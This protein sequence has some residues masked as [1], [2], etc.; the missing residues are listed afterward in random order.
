MEGKE[1]NDLVED[2]FKSSTVRW[3]KEQTEYLEKITRAQSNCLH[4][5]EYRSGRITG[6]KIY[7]V[8]HT[9]R[10]QPSASL[11]KSICNPLATSN[12]HSQSLKWGGSHE[13]IAIKS[14][15]EY[16]EQRHQN[17]QFQSIGFKIN[18]EI[19][20]Y[21]G[22]SPDG[23]VSCDC[24]GTGLVEVKCSYKYRDIMPTDVKSDPQYCLEIKENDVRIKDTHRYAEKVQFNMYVC[25]EN[26]CDF[27]VWTLKG[28]VVCRILRKQNYFENKV[29]LIE[30]F[31]K[32]H[33]VP[34]LLTRR[35]ELTE[36]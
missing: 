10:N 21:L 7:D 5:F 32:R 28:M 12:L 36:E 1:L 34:E 26:Y 31:Y 14:Y 4:W 18:P 3:N 17:L 15:I 9:N 23:Y 13:A 8:L 16:A 25:N 29:S 2:T 6:T 11:I 35:F 22:C 24:H 27:V 33:I 30:E 19:P 20:F